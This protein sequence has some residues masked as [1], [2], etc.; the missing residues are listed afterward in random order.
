MKL[1]DLELLDL[2]DDRLE[3]QVLVGADQGQDDDHEGARA[4]DG[5]QVKDV[6]QLEDAVQQEDQGGGVGLGQGLV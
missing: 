4:E 3:L 2:L 6:D 1:D 5:V